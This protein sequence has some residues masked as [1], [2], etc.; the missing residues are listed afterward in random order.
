MIQELAMDT[1]RAARY[2][3]APYT[4]PFL[5]I[6]DLWV[7]RLS[8]SFAWRC[9]AE[10]MLSLYDEHLGRRHLEVGPG[11]G[12]YLANTTAASE[13]ITLMDLN[14][15]PMEFT[16]RRLADRDTTVDT[17]IGSVLE[18]VPASAG[19]QYDSIGMN[20]VLHCAPGG[21]DD[22]GIAFTHL[23]RILADDGV[24][25]GST[26]LNRRPRTRFG[27]ALSFAYR[28]IGAFNNDADDRAG[29]ERALRES[30]RHFQ[31]AE[32]GDVT[33]FRARRPRREVQP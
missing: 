27:R 23:G 9:A 12:W 33:L 31:I 1:D 32:V 14:P 22:K 20:F 18:P 16:S 3:V 7:I 29:L 19:T 6:Y 10:T 25:F 15:T 4:S 26:I 17:V 2:A 30:F 11:S 28:R 8:N 24:L 21:L 13:Q 5:A